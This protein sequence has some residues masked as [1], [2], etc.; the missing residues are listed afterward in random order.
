MSPTN[1]A[2]KKKK[3]ITLGVVHINSGRKTEARK[4]W[5]KGLEYDPDNST[6]KQ[7]INSLE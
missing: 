3:N 1:K 7:Y 6:L 5:V 4:A 2:K